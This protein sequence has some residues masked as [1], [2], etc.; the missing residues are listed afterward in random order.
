MSEHTNIL[1]NRMRSATSAA[2]R[3]ILMQQADVSMASDSDDRA[4]AADVARRANQQKAVIKYSNTISRIALDIG[5]SI[6]NDDTRAAMRSMQN[7]KSW[8]TVM[9]S[10]IK[11]LEY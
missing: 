10:L 5:T 8:V 3:K 4:Q 1:A 2:Q 11:D 7:L 6:Q 9:E